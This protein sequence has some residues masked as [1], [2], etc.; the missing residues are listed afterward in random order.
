MYGPKEA[1]TV[2][3]RILKAREAEMLRKFRWEEPMRSRFLT[4]GLVL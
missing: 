3:S 2:S 4:M 1:A